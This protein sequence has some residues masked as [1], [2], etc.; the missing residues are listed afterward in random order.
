MRAVLAEPE[1]V[2]DD[3]CWCLAEQSSHRCSATRPNGERSELGAESSAETFFG[4]GLAGSVSGEEPLRA[5]TVVQGAPLGVMRQRA[6]E[7]V[8]GL[9]D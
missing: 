4:D 7:P 6:Q 9:G 1:E 8:D 3:R 5:R 2:S